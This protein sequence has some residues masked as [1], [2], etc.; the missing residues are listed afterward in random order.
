MLG[1][2]GLDPWIGSGG[3]H[4]L[5]RELIRLLNDRDIKVFAD[6]ADQQRSDI[7]S[8]AWKSA[9]QLDLPPQWHLEWDNFITALTESHIRVKQGEDELVW[10]MAD[11]DIYA[12]KQGY[13]TL[14]MHK[15]P[16]S[17]CNWWKDIWQLKSFPRT[18][19]FFWC[20]LKDIVPTGEHLSHRA[21]YM[22][23][24]CILCKV[25]EESTVH[26]FLHCPVTQALWQNI[27]SSL[28]FTGTWNG[29]DIQNSWDDCK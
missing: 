17:L 23:S 28:G 22:P 19:L 4:I 21:I 18:K 5:S 14:I 1:R 27:S 25:A 2:I 20:V 26:L 8:Q 12:P 9:L 7:F 16:D 13:N 10:C 6:I 29:V 3:R 11:N 24:W 15:K